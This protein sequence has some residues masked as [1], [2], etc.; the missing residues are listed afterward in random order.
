MNIYETSLFFHSF[1]GQLRIH[2]PVARQGVGDAAG[3]HR[4]ADGGQLEAPV[5]AAQKCKTFTW[6]AQKDGL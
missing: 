6:F 1:H 2:A 5:P 4:H 3:E